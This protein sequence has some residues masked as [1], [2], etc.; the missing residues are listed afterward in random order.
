MKNIGKGILGKKEWHLGGPTKHEMVG[1]ESTNCSWSYK[2]CLETRGRSWRKSNAQLRVW[3]LPMAKR[4]PFWKFM[5]RGVDFYS[6]R[7]RGQ[8]GS[9]G[10]AG[11]WEVVEKQLQWS[12][13]E[14]PWPEMH[15]DG[16]GRRQ[17]ADLLVQAVESTDSVYDGVVPKGRKG[18]GI[19][20]R[21]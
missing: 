11:G 10:K 7:L 6:P 15:D 5:P 14:K 16:E 13:C 19:N 20:P 3:I 2:V 1:V 8:I 4:E 18:E 17:W 21:V 12:I 9:E